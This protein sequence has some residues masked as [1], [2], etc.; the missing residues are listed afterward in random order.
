MRGSINRRIAL[1]IRCSRAP[2]A[3]A[4]LRPLALPL[5]GVEEALEPRAH[6]FRAWRST[7]FVTSNAPAKPPAK[8]RWSPENAGE[9]KINGDDAGSPVR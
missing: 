7:R 2:W 8:T 4:S 1:T 6:Q 9:R 3:S 5:V